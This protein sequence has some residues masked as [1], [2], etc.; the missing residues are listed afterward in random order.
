[1]KSYFLSL[2][3]LVTVLQAVAA[4]PRIVYTKTFPGSTPPYSSIALERSGDGIYKDA[5]DDEA[6]A[7]FHLSAADTAAI[8]D[9]A[10]KVDFFKRPLES[11]L[12]VANMGTKSFRWESEGDPSEVKFNYTQDENGRLLQD[13]FERIAESE[14]HYFALERSI[15]FD[16]LGVHKTLIDLNVTWDR[17]RLVAIEQFLP[18]LDRIAKNES[19]L[20]MARERAAQLAAAIREKAA[21]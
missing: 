4:D 7:K 2:A 17:K 20:H 10:A 8:F 19:F 14:L 3:F 13:W 15:K 21:E 16:R 1:M 12:K 11:G 18:M 6:P 9:L 5:P